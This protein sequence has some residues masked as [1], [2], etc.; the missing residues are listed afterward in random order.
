MNRVRL[1]RF[2]IAG[3]VATA[4][5]ADPV[6]AQN[7]LRDS[8]TEAFFRDLGKPLEEAAGL[9]PRSVEIALVGDKSI[10]AFAAGGQNVFINSGTIIAADNVNQLQGVVAHELGHVADGHLVRFNEGASAA[11]GISLLSLLLGA[12]A[13]AAGAGDAGMGIMM[14]GQEAAQGKFLAF[15]RVIESSA[16]Q[17]GASFLQKSG[18]T[19]KGMLE[20]FDKLTAQQ[21]RYGF[22][23]K[24]LDTYAQTHPL[25]QDRV[26]ALE[27]VLKKSPSWNK[28]V[29]PVL[30]A[31]FMRIKAK[32]VGFVEEPARTFQLY[33]ESDQ[34][35]PAHYAR[36]YAFHKQAFPDKATAEADAL[37]R[38]APND[39]YFNELKGQ[40][41]LESGR[42][43]E[44]IAPLRLAVTM[45]PDQ[46]LIA[47]LLG[48]ALIESEDK[49]NFAE[50]QGILKTAIARDN[51]NPFAWYQLG[52][53]YDRLGDQPRAAL[54]SAERYNLMGVAPQA[55]SNA[56]MAMNGLKR[57]SPDWLRAQD[58]A[59]V[60][61]TDL[62]GKKKRRD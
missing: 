44:A 58:I 26:T 17:A 53:I 27:D 46:P 33:P 43:K 45:A 25:S 40:I 9:N 39:P 55:L 50:A 1:V 62:Q 48:S 56:R 49:A 11:S 19:G 18:T 34:S 23:K 47:S 10:N 2:L 8:E 7:I 31:R 37:L 36:A 60:S 15:S 3:L 59:M 28:P 16:D 42:V 4:L 52:V 14:A 5:G 51:S 61:E 41:L 20:F 30:N 24:D 35:V 29:D 21:Y 6:A 12:A 54:A 38:Q 22:A 57:G 13:L 32:L